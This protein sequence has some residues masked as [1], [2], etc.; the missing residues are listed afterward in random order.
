MREH[1][2]ET[3]RTEHGNLLGFTRKRVADLEEAED[4]LQEVYSRAMDTIN[5]LDPID[6]IAGWLY[7]SVHNR[8]IDWYRKKKNKAVSLDI[9]NEQ[10]E[11]LLDLIKDSGIDIQTDF[12][13]NEVINE[14]MKAID[15]LPELQREIIIRQAIEGSSFREISEE[16]GVSIN[17]LLAR[18]RYAIKTL[19]KRLEIM[20]EIIDEIST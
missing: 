19:R 4:I 13:R 15:E 12:I 10:G 16:T 5:R 9:E 17:T 11:S 8:I 1:L 3:F 14:L 18:K 20:K 2:E 6:N 7:R